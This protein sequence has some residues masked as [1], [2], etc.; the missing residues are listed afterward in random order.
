MDIREASDLLTKILEEKKKEQKDLKAQY[1]VT[2]TETREITMDNFEF[3]LFRTLFDTSASVSVIAD[4]K[5]GKTVTNQL[6]E[7]NLKQAVEDA[8]A[9]SA[10]GVAE[11]YYDI[12]PGLTPEEFSFGPLEPDVDK[13]LE[14]GAEL[15][16]EIKENYPRIMMRTMILKYVCSHGIYR[17]T[18]GSE[19]EVTSGYYAVTVTFAGH[20][21]D[22]T[23]GM[24]GSYVAMKDLDTPFIEL[25]NVRTALEY[26]QKSLDPMTI[27]G[28]FE[29]P[30]IFTPDCFAQV[31]YYGLGVLI[32][33]SVIQDRTSLWKDKM[34]EKVAAD[35]LTV[36]LRPWD[37]RIVGHEVHTEDGFRSE[38]YDAIKDGVLKS[39]AINLYTANKC[40][41]ERAK[42]SGFDLII[43]PGN[44]ALEDMIAG[45]KK[46]L[47]VGSVSCGRP[48]A[49][50]ELAGV[51]KNAFYVED[52]KIVNAVMET[53]ISFKISDLLQN[54]TEISKETVCDGG[55]VVPYVKAEHVLISGK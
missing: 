21:G 39:F 15:A 12:A 1:T 18:N 25:G 29:G 19:D 49:N 32:D 30:V 11:P 35:L 17:S 46:G 2:E 6:N 10:S 4:Q 50:T 42:N 53:M 28:K 44:T 37:E 20:E 51:A 48:S 45:V 36:G 3:S 24:S 40:K 14:R 47:I 33:D 8:I 7:E 13:L 41:A 55:M 27:E 38:D 52:G 9:A 34:G 31:L 23:T 43:E 16:K 5:P 54:I 22:K 26:A